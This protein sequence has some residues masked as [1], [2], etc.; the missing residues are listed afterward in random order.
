MG[1]MHT[2]FNITLGPV[3]N[4]VLNLAKITIIPVL[5]GKTLILRR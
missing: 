5:I 1:N 3:C 4:Y 2:S